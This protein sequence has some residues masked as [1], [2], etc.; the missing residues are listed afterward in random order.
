[1]CHNASV[2]EI[3]V[4]LFFEADTVRCDIGCHRRPGKKRKK[5]FLINEIHGHDGVLPSDHRM[6]DSISVPSIA[7]FH[8]YDRSI[9]LCYQNNHA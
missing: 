9:L 4:F 7:W 1:M 6:Y 5:I 2:P 3:L 8:S